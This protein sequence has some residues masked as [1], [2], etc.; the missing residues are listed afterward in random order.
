[1]KKLLLT[2]LPLA[3][4]TY[5]GAKALARLQELVEVTLHEGDDPLDRPSRRDQVDRICE[6][7]MTPGGQGKTERNERERAAPHSSPN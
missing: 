5:Y 7:G 4:R 3:R 2:H 6:E 1:M